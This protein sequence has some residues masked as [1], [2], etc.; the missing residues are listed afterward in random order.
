MFVP[1]LTACL[2]LFLTSYGYAA[3]Q[4]NANT[5]TVVNRLTYLSF[6]FE[7][8]NP[9][10]S[11]P[12]Y[13]MPPGVELV[14]STLRTEPGN[15]IINHADMD[16]F[17]E[18]EGIFSLGPFVFH[19][20]S[21]GSYSVP[22]TKVE[23]VSEETILSPNNKVSTAD[24]PPKFYTYKPYPKIYPNTPVFFILEVSGTFK[25]IDITWPGWQEVY[26]E[27]VEEN[28]KTNGVLEIKY[29][30]MFSREGSYSLA[31]LKFHLRRNNKD[32]FF[33]SSPLN[34]Q[35]DPVPMNGKASAALGDYTL[36]ITPYTGTNKDYV[37]IDV[38]Y[39]GKGYL[40]DIKPPLLSVAP[41]ADILLRKRLVNF[42]SYYPEPQGKVEFKY[43]FLPPN[44]GLY[45]IESKPAKTFDPLK[46]VFKNIS[47]YTASIQVMLP[48][49]PAASGKDNEF[50]KRLQ[51]R[52]RLDYD[53]Y[54]LISIVMLVT[55]F[56]IGLYLKGRFRQRKNP[57]QLHA[58]Q[59]EDPLAAIQRAVLV[60]LRHIT[61]EDFLTTPLSQIKESLQKSS[62]EESF[63][64]EILR[65]LD[66]MFKFR[67]LRTSSPS[68]AEQLKEKGLE[69][70]QRLREEK[71]KIKD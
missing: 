15:K 13:V 53:L 56:A 20:K 23:V 16:V 49:N 68:L 39:T 47:S 21:G 58:S 50:Q 10:Y 43:F 63:R 24:V 59:S 7:S 3:E 31:P 46:S 61:K 35:V 71:E 52:K 64:N 34:F 69:L 30:I 6:A 51:I 45:K 48:S 11:N 32:Y 67:Y 40:R 19:D 33:S 25:A 2:S 37:Q 60:Y 66:E 1:L 38:V 70:L 17:F 29:M 27:K 42:V 65:W 54:V 22:P 36:N 41:A 55:F 4:P 14:S 18:K 9:A 62:L 5:K 57:A 26:S 8:A 44:D 28:I 12:A